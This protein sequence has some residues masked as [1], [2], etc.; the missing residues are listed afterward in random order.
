[1]ADYKTVT[2]TLII[3]ADDSVSTTAGSSAEAVNDYIESLDSGT[4]PILHLKVTQLNGHD[5]LVTIVSTEP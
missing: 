1:M 4:H 2:R 3:R 5:I